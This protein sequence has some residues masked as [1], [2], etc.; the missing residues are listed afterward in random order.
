[1]SFNFVKD[2][3]VQTSKELTTLLASQHLQSPCHRQNWSHKDSFWNLLS[4]SCLQAQIGLSLLASP[5]HRK[6]DWFLKVLLF[7]G[8]NLQK[9]KYHKIVF[10]THQ[11]LLLYSNIKLPFWLNYLKWMLYK[12]KEKKWNRNDLFFSPVSWKCTYFHKTLWK[13]FQHIQKKCS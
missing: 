6:Q 4:W 3:L 11:N 13:C 9:N 12:E 2:V 5:P 1:M 7:K 10:Q 8:E